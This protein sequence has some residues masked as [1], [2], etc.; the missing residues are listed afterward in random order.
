MWPDI[1]CYSIDSYIQSFFIYPSLY[2]Y[3][4]STVDGARTRWVLRVCRYTEHH[5]RPWLAHPLVGEAEIQ[6]K[7]HQM[8]SVKNESL[9]MALHEHRG[10]DN[11]RWIEQGQESIYHMASWGWDPFKQKEQDKGRDA[12][13]RI[14]RRNKAQPYNSF[15]NVR[16]TMHPG[17]WVARAEARDGRCRSWKPTWIAWIHVN[18]CELGF[19]PL[20]AFYS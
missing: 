4:P 15:K 12:G 6:T 19:H 17:C 2:K 5:I 3:L 11:W 13:E 10:R 18:K 14:T 9:Y 16:I 20:G 1:F 7:K 8:L